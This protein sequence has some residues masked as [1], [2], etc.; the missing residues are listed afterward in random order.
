[1]VKV[2]AQAVG[3]LGRK[4]GSEQNALGQ[5]VSLR[6]A[7]LDAE[8]AI[9]NWARCAAVSSWRHHRSI[10]HRA[11][12][13]Q[14]GRVELTKAQLIEAFANPQ[15]IASGAELRDGKLFV[16]QA[17][18]DDAGAVLIDGRSVAATGTASKSTTPNP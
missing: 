9:N 11:L 17:M 10:G 6:R 3:L 16:Q 8:V 12:L 2:L 7:D 14:H 18:T 15:T 1:M 13:Q 5:L 4:G